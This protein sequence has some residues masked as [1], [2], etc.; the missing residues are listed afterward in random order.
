V[1]KKIADAA[2]IDDM[3]LFVYYFDISSQDKEI[4]SETGPIFI[5]FC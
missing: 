3:L 2:K 4:V 1:E 5:P